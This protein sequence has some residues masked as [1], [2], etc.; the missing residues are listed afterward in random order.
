V[1]KHAILDLDLPGDLP[2]IR[3]NAAQI[4]Q[5]VV[6]LV[7]NA[8]EAIGERDG[9]IG[10]HAT[11]VAIGRH[12]SEMDAVNLCEGEYVRLEISDTGCGIP[13]EIRF[14]IFDPFFTTKFTG[15]GLGLAVVQGIVRGYG[16]TIN[17]VSSPGAGTVFEV[18]LPVAAEPV[19]GDDAVQKPALAAVGESAGPRRAVFVVEDEESLRN[20]VCKMLRKKN[21]SI[22]EAEDGSAAVEI[23]RDR[24]ADIG[25][26]LLDLTMP[27]LGGREVLSELKRIRPDVKIIVTTAYS[28]DAAAASLDS[29]RGWAF[30]RKPYQIADL[31][32]LLHKGLG[33]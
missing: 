23:F 28:Q 13:E 33:S 26:V 22:L 4:S 21:F 2:V 12:S 19:R 7:M 5:V 1:S 24:H 18:Y 29:E 16:G 8:S 31:I 9:V 32:H 14:R 11:R 10:V 17:V 27:G 25:L 15:R 6:N 3:A 30:I 20:A